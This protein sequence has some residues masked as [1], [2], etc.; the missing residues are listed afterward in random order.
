MYVHNVQQNENKTMLV[1]V[2]ALYSVVDWL[3]FVVY[4]EHMYDLV[5]HNRQ[6]IKWMKTGAASS[7]IGLVRAIAA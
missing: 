6:R 2:R 3:W 4:T 1:L 7:T 5:I